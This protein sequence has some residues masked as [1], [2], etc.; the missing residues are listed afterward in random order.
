MLLEGDEKDQNEQQNNPHKI[1]SAMTRSR[2]HP[3]RLSHDKTMSHGR[4]YTF[5]ALLP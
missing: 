5:E 3:A 1:N 4:A 2:Y